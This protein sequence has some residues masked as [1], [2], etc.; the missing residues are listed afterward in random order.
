MY[1]PNIAG[2]A[3]EPL[4]TLA[5]QHSRH[6]G[7]EASHWHATIYTCQLQHQQV[8]VNASHKQDAL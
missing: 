7:N 6:I 2:L 8:G 5:H 4:S 3:C 1:I